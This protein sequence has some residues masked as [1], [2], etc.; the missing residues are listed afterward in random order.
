M[1]PS[2]A[3]AQIAVLSMNVRTGNDEQIKTAV[4][5]ELRWEPSV[6][7]AHIGVTARDGVVTLTGNVRSFAERYAAEQAAQRVKGVKAVAADIEVR[8]PFEVKRRDEEIAAAIVDHLA[9]DSEVPKDSIKAKV[10]KGNVTLTGQVDY[11]FQQQ[12]AESHVRR[13]SGVISVLN[14]VTIKPQVDTPHLSDDIQHALNRSWFFDPEL[15]HVSAQGGKV[16]LTGT[17]HTPHD[18]RKAAM[19]AWAAHGAT[20]VENDILVG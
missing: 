9:W 8:L 12:A 10:S 16:K 18:R 17:V 7:E 14:N 1:R 2:P 13:L 5:E 4:L 11:H 3:L 6:T 19:T 15:V 20:S